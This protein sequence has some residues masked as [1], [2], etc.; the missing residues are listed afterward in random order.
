MTPAPAQDTQG[1]CGS[2]LPSGEGPPTPKPYSPS[3]R[4][5]CFHLLPPNVLGCQLPGTRGGCADRVCESSSEGKDGGP[6]EMVPAV[7]LAEG[8]RDGGPG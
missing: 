1:S 7:P 5:R 3:L 4:Q 8:W 6:R 2:P